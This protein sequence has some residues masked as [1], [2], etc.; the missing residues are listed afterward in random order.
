MLLVRDVVVH[1]LGV[2]L[3]LEVED[4][5]FILGE[6]PGVG[7]T[8]DEGVIAASTR[9]SNTAAADSPNVRPEHAGRRLLAV[10]ERQ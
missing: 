2:S 4:G 7:V 6:A 8:V 10:A 5:S 1:Q 3:D 9:R